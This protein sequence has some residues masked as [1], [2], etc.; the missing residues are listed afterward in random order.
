MWEMEWLNYFHWRS[1]IQLAALICQRVLR[2]DHTEIS[3]FVLN[4]T[5]YHF[6]DF[7]KL[8]TGSV[9]TTSG[10]LCFLSFLFSVVCFAGTCDGGV[11]GGQAESLG[12]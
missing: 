11:G 8:R 12:L 4:L 3:S 7:F 10:V 5:L 6:I 1:V 9:S 2:G